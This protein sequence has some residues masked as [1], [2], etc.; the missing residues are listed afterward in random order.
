MLKVWMLSWAKASETKTI[1]L[2]WT[3]AT[4][5]LT[6]EVLVLG[7]VLATAFRGEAVEEKEGG[8]GVD[9][10]D[11]A[12]HRLG[13]VG[14]ENDLRQHVEH[15]H[16]NEVEVQVLAKEALLDAGMEVGMQVFLD[17]GADAGKKLILEGG[18]EAG[19]LLEKE[20][21]KLESV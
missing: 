8:L 5:G 10:G 12:A 21:L 18:G 3:R 17:E 2:Y 1:R 9:F 14:I 16:R 19:Q 4:I 11:G 7:E 20:G 15:P 6:D 13:K